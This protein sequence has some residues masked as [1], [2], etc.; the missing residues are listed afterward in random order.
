MADGTKSYALQDLWEKVNALWNYAFQTASVW[1]RDGARDTRVYQLADLR[2][3]HE[4]QGPAVVID[5][6]STVIVNPG[7]TASITEQGSID[8]AV[9]WVCCMRRV[10]HV[11]SFGI[12]FFGRFLKYM[13]FFTCDDFFGDVFFCCH[14]LVGWIKFS[15]DV[16]TRASLLPCVRL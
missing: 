2:P 15:V 16:C 1:F 12:L 11:I 10:L 6:N 7:C 14:S 4:V 13:Y 3:G 9:S 5:S 8:I